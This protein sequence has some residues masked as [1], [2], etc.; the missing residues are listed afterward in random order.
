M[1][2]VDFRP[3]FAALKEINYDGW[4][5]VEVFKY[6][7][8]PDEIA[9]RASSTCGRSKQRCSWPCEA[10]S[11]CMAASETATATRSPRAARPDAGPSRR[12]GPSSR[13]CIRAGRRFGRRRRPRSRSAPF[14]SRPTGRPSARTGSSSCR[15]MWTHTSQ[16]TQRSRSISHHCCVPFTM[17]R[18]IFFSS[19]QST[20][21]TSRHDSQPVQLSALMTANSFGTFLR[22]PSLA[23]CRVEG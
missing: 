19:M 4:V 6:E 15:G 23:M 2:D 3:I 9:R 7:P 1:G 22:G 14:R 11:Q 17:P 5:S 8:S 18:S 13:E 21:Q 16:P 12:A 10:G 20:G